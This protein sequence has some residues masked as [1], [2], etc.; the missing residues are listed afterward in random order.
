MHVLDIV[1]WIVVAI[2]VIFI[3]HFLYLVAHSGLSAAVT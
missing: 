2:V 1:L 3:G